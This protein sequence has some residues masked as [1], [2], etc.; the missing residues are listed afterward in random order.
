MANRKK[1]IKKDVR[2]QVCLTEEQKNELQSICEKRGIG[3]S[4]QLTLLINDFITN[5]K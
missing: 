1:E 2:V 4:T 3:M 5:S